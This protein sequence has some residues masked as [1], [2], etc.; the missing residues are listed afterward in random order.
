VERADA[1]VVGGG[2]AGSTCAWKLRQAGL[3]VLVLDRA[4]FPRTKLCAGWITPEVVQDLEIDIERYPHR[5]LTFERLEFNWR[6]LRF[7]KTTVQHSIRRYEFDDWLLRRSGARYVR[8]KVKSIEA[9]ND[10][11]VIDGEY[12]CR[13]LVGAGGTACPV[14]RQL[15]SERA[16][17]DSSLQI[18]TY[19]Q[20]FPYAWQNGECKLWFF[21]NGLPGYAWYV[22][23]ADGYLNI[24][25]GGKA[26]SIKNQGKNGGASIKEHWQR[27]VE[28]LER[29][30]LVRGHDWEPSGY[31][32]YLRGRAGAVRLGNAF[33]VG[34]AVGLASV[35]MGE[36]IGPAVRSAIAA[37][38][39]IT[40]GAEY[41]L[42]HV[43]RY[44]VPGFFR[45]HPRPAAAEG[46]RVPRSDP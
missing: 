10:G 17:R 4:E 34:D 21:E 32:Y 43:S 5:L 42:D 23:K 26:D 20:E 37:A 24:G 38:R 28:R 14:Y 8:H 16:P 27:F 2:P 30:G 18:A 33:I 3:D 46:M 25:L 6:R 35:D 22:P 44:S 11:F 36:G 9:R 15:F 12:E 13:W 39:A 40:T 29:E 1:I 41:T 31:S 7:R 19:E 45:R